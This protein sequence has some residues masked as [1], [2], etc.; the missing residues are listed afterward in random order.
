[1]RLPKRTSTIRSLPPEEV[2]AMRR[3]AQ[4]PAG[5]WAYYSELAGG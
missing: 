1:M 5:R 3:E 4:P 2:E